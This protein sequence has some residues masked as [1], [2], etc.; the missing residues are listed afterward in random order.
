MRR[1]YGSGRDQ[2]M[3][4]ERVHLALQIAAPEP[5]ASHL[6]TARAGNELPAVFADSAYVKH[7]P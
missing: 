2:R 5:F 4:V 7:T 6:T 3:L 1:R